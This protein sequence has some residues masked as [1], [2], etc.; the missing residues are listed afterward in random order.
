MAGCRPF[1]DDE[2][3]DILS[4]FGGTFATR[5]RSLFLLG[6]KSGFRISELLSLRIGDVMR[7]GSIVSSVTVARRNMKKKTAGRTVLL[8][9]EVKAALFAWISE[10]DPKG[11]RMRDTFLFHSR[12]GG[13]RPISRQ[14]YRRILGEIYDSLEITGNTGTHSMRKTYARRAYEITG[15]DLFQTQKLLGHVNINSTVS[16]LSSTDEEISRLMLMI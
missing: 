16:Y 12:K 7:N 10:L 11:S 13:N 9:P 14:Q 8:Q 4:S 1:T 15:K 3:A 2:V 6:V 5:D